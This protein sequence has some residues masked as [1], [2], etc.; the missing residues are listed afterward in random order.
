M[1]TEKKLDY[2]SNLNAHSNNNDFI[3]HFN[4]NVQFFEIFFLFL[5][6]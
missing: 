2:A 5:K 4:N 6:S 1:S 3:M